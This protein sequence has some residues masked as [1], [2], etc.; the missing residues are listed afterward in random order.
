VQTSTGLLISEAAS[1]VRCGLWYAG[2]CAVGRRFP[3]D[4]QNPLP[5]ELPSRP[6]QQAIPRKKLHALKSR[7]LPVI[8]VAALPLNSS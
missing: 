4:A 2:F 3:P 7:F 6:S 5:P 8:A 1:A